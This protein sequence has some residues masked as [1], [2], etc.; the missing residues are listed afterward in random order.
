LYHLVDKIYYKSVYFVNTKIKKIIF[1]RL[2][3]FI[4]T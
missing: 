2:R 4:N 1:P 3:Q